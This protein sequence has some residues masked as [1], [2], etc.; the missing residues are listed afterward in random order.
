MSAW[1]DVTHESATN[2]EYP[3]VADLDRDG[4]ADI[5][6]ASN[7]YTHPNERALIAL[8]HA[9]AGWAPVGTAWPSHDFAQVSPAADGSVPAYLGP[10]WETLGVYRAR[11][12][13][14]RV[15]TPDL[16]VQITDVCV[17][18][19]T[20]GPVEVAVWVWNEG[21]IDTPAGGEVSLYAVSSGVRTLVATQTLPTV[22][23]GEALG[24]TFFS[25]DPAVVGTDGWVA[26]VRTPW[27]G[28]DCDDADDEATWSDGACP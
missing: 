16:A 10:Y 4:H 3:I 23:A 13:D 8:S 6:Y 14:D 20:L 28:W 27:P 12:S 1:S 22:Q 2:V 21:V 18:D 15:E 26:T 7:G 5:V 24:G 25:L 19:C 17:A 11:T 9:G